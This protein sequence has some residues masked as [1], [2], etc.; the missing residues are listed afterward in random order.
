MATCL[1]NTDNVTHRGDDV[2]VEDKSIHVAAVLELR[3]RVAVV[4]IVDENF[5]LLLSA[6]YSVRCNS[7][8][9]A[10]QVVLQK[11]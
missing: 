10:E 5:K 8:D 9:S 6:K 7:S 1:H 3:K 11:T 4:G 2:D